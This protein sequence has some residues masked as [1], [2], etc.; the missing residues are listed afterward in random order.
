MGKGAEGEGGEGGEKEPREKGEEP[1]GG[2]QGG[3][4]SRPQEPVRAAPGRV[5]ELL[6]RF[7]TYK[8]S[9]GHQPPQR[10]LFPLPAHMFTHVNC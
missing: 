6:Q 3:G 8:T 9:Q 4:Q 1:G 5:W 10:Q 7:P 2:G